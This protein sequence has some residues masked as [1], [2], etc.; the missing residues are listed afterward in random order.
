MWIGF[1]DR[2]GFWNDLYQFILKYILDLYFHPDFLLVHEVGLELVK[3]TGSEVDDHFGA[4]HPILVSSV[5]ESQ[6]CIHFHQSVEIGPTQV[7]IDRLLIDCNNHLP[8]SLHNVPYS[9]GLPGIKFYP[10]IH[11]H[12]LSRFDFMGKFRVSKQ[13]AAELTATKE[14][15]YAVIRQ[16]RGDPERALSTHWRGV[17]RS[18][19]PLTRYLSLWA[20]AAI[21]AVV[22]LATYSVLLLQ[23][24]TQSDPVA[25][26]LAGLG[27]KVPVLP[28]KRYQPP[29]ALRLTDLLADEIKLKQLQVLQERNTEIVILQGDEYF[30][31]GQARLVDAQHQVLMQ[32]AA[33]LQKIPGRI[34]ITGHTDSIP[35]RTLRFPSNWDLSRERARTV[36]SVLAEMLPADRMEIEAKADT[37]PLAPNDTPSNR[38]LNRRVEIVLFP[39]VGGNA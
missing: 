3:A 35:I 15:V 19:A 12:P 6:T 13:G 36:H 38:A 21:A 9:I 10:D 7:F 39:A 25:V 29:P 23:L 2:I 34:A 27:N 18:L 30:R 20:A 4:G 22:L 24:N 32:V 33:A 14:R 31:S 1:G 16:Q 26:E 17:D 8:V 11:F 28:V 5:E 37:S